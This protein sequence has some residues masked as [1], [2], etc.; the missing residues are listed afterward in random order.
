MNKFKL[1][2][3]MSEK[4]DGGK[5]YIYSFILRK[6]LDMARIMTKDYIQ[7][8]RYKNLD[9]YTHVSVQ[10]FRCPEKVYM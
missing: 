3:D 10:I 6:L 5:R 8:T 9:T 4:H 7:K 1:N 2:R